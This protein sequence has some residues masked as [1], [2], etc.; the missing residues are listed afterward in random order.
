MVF[1]PPTHLLW[2]FWLAPR[3]AGSDDP[4]HLFYLQAPRDLPDAEMRHERATVGHAVSSN[5]VDWVERGT[6]FAPAPEGSWDDLAIW[7]GSIVEHEGTHYFF[8]T[9][10]SRQDRTQRIGLATSTDPA[11]ERWE[12]YAENPILVADPRWYEQPDA[13][14]W[15]DGQACRDP[16]VTYS[17][18][19][20]AWYMF[21]TAR[22]N[23]GPVDGR[24]VVGLA[25]SADLLHWEQLPPVSEPG[26]FGHLEVPQPVELDGRWYLLFCTNLHGESRRRRIPSEARW[27]GT[28][29]LVGDRLTGP[30]ALSTDTALLADEARTFYA[31]RVVE[32]PD[33][34]LVFLAWRGRDDAG[35]FLGA[36]SNPAPLRV[37]PDGGLH[38]DAAALWPGGPTASGPDHHS[39]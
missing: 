25:R 16:W 39:I 34:Q 19:E 8:Y 26:E 1:T 35:D 10:R 11:L 14:N 27:S 7:T 12:R 28:H 21:F 23:H 20:R 31:G 9:G 37:L 32:N 3:R 38:V 29:Y 4:Y 33:G 17:K 30:Y 24:G 18:E 15:P 22:A 2:D 13:V 36:L 5:L 6:A